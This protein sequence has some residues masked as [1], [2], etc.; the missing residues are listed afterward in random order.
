M[1]KSIVKTGKLSISPR[2]FSL[3]LTLSAFFVAVGLAL[4]FAKLINIAGVCLIFA[5]IFWNFFTTINTLVSFIMSIVVGVIYALFAVNEGLYVNAFLYTMFYIGMQMSM[6][7]LYTGQ[8]SEGIIEY[9]SLRGLHIYRLVLAFLLSVM[10]CFAMAVV[11]PG[12]K[13]LFFDVAVA[14]ALGLSAYLESLRYREYFVVRPI[15]LALAIALFAYIAATRGASTGVI[16]I[17]V[18]YSSYLVLDIV[19]IVGYALEKQDTAVVDRQRQQMELGK[20][21]LGQRIE[22]YNSLEKQKEEDKQKQGKTKLK[23]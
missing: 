18:L 20:E 3:R 11:T 4:Y 16:A 12:E 22:E 17:L 23:A 13:F 8:G 10:I 2:H 14:C 6:W 19:K 1:E 21:K 5:G 9:R 7:L 15:A